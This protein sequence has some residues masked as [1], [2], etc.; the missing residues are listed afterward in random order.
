MDIA[1]E[2]VT[3]LFVKGTEVTVTGVL[4][5]PLFDGSQLVSVFF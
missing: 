2:F 4:V 5:N 3:G 1:S